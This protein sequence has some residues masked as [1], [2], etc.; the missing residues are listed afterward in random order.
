MAWA[1]S[2]SPPAWPA[3]ISGSAALLAIGYLTGLIGEHH[4]FP[5]REYA[6]RRDLQ[7]ECMEGSVIP[8]ALVD[9]QTQKPDFLRCKGFTAMV[10]HAQ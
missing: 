5:F 10:R 4:N 3:R 2:T 7:L 8:R 6:D 9:P 1:S